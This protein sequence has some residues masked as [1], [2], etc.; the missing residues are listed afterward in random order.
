MA[1]K[2][3]LLGTILAGTFIAGAAHATILFSPTD[4][5]SGD[6]QTIQFETVAVGSS[7]T[8]DTNKTHTP[9]TFSTLSGQT[10]TTDGI[11]Q[12]NIICSANC[13]NNGTSNT[14][15]QLTSLRVTVGGGFGATDFI[16]NLDFGEGTAQI[17]VTDQMGAVFDYTLSNGQNF[18]T[19]T[20]INGEVITDIQITA[21]SSNTGNFGWNDFKQP[22]ISGV[23]T[24]EGT[25]CAAIPTPEPGSLAL[26][27]CGLLGLGLLRRRRS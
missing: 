1:I 27:A 17:A 23:C 14:N 2:Q 26:V 22:R 5:P 4:S 20:A 25:T 12:A 16:G 13:F 10:I 21:A 24:L 9:V 15:S 6:E 18:F 7:L 8:G 11:G 3:V 19:L